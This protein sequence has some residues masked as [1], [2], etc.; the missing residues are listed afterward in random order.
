M[1]KN[2]KLLPLDDRPYE[3]LE[4]IGEN[5]LTNSELLAIIIKTGTK[6]Y[7]CLEIAQ[8]ILKTKENIS[9]ISDLEYLTNLSLEELKSYE[10]IGRVKAIQIKA[11]LELSKRIASMYVIDKKSITSPKDVFNL[12]RKEFIGKKQEVLKTIILNKKNTIISVIT[13][14]IGNNDNISIGIK[15]I[16]SE[17]IKQMANSIILVH[18]HPS[19]NLKPSKADILFTKKI[20]ENVKLFDITLLDHIIISDKGYISLKEIH[21]FN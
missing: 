1:A 12:L 10:G 2:I 16:L 20:N 5:N 7:N 21:K 17:P 3:K 8:N 11:M 6:K 18:N 19:G 15:E 4:L 14:A 9:K 13:N